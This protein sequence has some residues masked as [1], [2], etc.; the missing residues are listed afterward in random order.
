[1]R[2]H[3]GRAEVRR[4]KQQL[5]ATFAHV[6]GAALSPELISHFSRYLCVL[7][8]GHVEQ[9]IKELIAQ[10]VRTKSSPQI[11]RFMGQRMRRVQNIDLDRLKELLESFDPAWWQ[12]LA[13]SR[14]DE[15]LALDSFAAVRNGVSHGA[16]SGITLGTIR[17][18]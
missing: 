4:R 13:L 15:L 12:A 14:P 8:S 3:Q 6:E 5:D 1:M 9:S 11:Q 18:Y 10:Y 17:Q 16:D 7:V 2:R